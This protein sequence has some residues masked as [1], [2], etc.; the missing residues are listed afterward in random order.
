MTRGI[1][2][3]L[4]AAHGLAVVALIVA[5]GWTHHKPYPCL[6]TFERV[7]E[8]MTL[9]EVEAT[10]GGPPGNYRTPGNLPALGGYIWRRSKLNNGSY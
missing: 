8:G 3:G 1:T 9:E 5:V 2:P 7:R 10:V 4:I 6:T